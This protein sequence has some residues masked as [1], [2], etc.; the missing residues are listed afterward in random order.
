MS[1]QSFSRNLG[2]RW[3]LS[4]ARNKQAL[5]SL[6]EQLPKTRT[7]L[8][9]LPD[10]ASEYKQI[11]QDIAEVESLLGK[12]RL[13]VVRK[14]SLPAPATAN[15][16]WDEGDLSYW[17]LLNRACKNRLL[18]IDYDL[19]IDLGLTFS[20]FNALLAHCSSAPLK[21]CFA[22]PQREAIYNVIL[23]VSAPSNWRKA[24]TVLKKHIHL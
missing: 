5:F 10:D 1:I 20:T 7:A 4:R 3:Y 23:Q 14:K 24:L 11:L 16:T 8:I 13:T 2:Q 6:R 19:V 12:T 17:G 21:V 18:A 15:Q 9:L 22:H